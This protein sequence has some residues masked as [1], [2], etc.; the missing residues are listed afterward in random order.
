MELEPIASPTT[1]LVFSTLAKCITSEDRFEVI[2]GKCVYT[3]TNGNN[4]SLV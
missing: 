2:G 4:V 3:V 1:R